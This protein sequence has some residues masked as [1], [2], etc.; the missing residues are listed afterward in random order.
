MHP[1]IS[2]ETKILAAICTLDMAA[3]AVLVHF[4]CAT[5][6]NP[7]MAAC[8]ERGIGVFILV[9]L[10]SFVPFLVIAER[11]RRRNPAFVQTALRCAIFLYTAVYTTVFLH[12]NLQL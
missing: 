12:V 9:K 10:M 6:F 11:H 4:H 5:E 8:F 1:K 7:L 2:L 3:T